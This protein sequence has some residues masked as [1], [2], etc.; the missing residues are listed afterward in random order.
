MVRCGGPGAVVGDAGSALVGSSTRRLT[1]ILISIGLTSTL[2]GAASENHHIST[3]M[4]S[5]MPP[6]DLTA[7]SPSQGS[8]GLALRLIVPARKYPNKPAVN[9]ATT[10][11]ILCLYKGN[12]SGEN[13]KTNIKKRIKIPPNIHEARACSLVRLFIRSPFR[14]HQSRRSSSRYC[15]ASAT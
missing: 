15:T 6:V 9:P 14:T 4:N 11:K 2:I 5:A 7:V 13:K 3:M 10:A 12:S 8:C 1:S